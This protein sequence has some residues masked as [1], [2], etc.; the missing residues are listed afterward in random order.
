MTSLLLYTH[1][2]FQAED[3]IRDFH[4]TGVQTCALPIYLVDLHDAAGPIPAETPAP[5]LS[6]AQQIA[7]GYESDEM[8]MILQPLA[9]GKE[10]TG[11]MGEDTP[12]AVLSRRPRLLYNYFKQLFAQVTN[13][14][15]DSIREKAVMSISMFL[16]GRLGL[17]EEL[18]KTAGLVELKT[19]ILYNHEVAAL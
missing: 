16:G 12:L 14:P 18:P 11:S 17:F 8:E 5:Q 4:V 15:I 9:E 2:F 1:F 13:P 6:V 19:P 7:F 3:G 10:P